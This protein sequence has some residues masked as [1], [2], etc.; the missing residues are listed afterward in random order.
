MI[1]TVTLNPC[2]DHVLFLDGLKVNDTNRVQRT[3]VDAGG[4]GVNVSRVAVELGAESLACGFLGGDPGTF[5]QS[6]L[7]I[8][9]VHHR[10]TKVGGTTRINFSVEDG[11]GKPPTTLNER[12]PKV[13]E[14]EWQQL[15][16]T[17]AEEAPKASWMSIG[18]SMPPGCPDDAFAQI[19]SLGKRSGCLV[20]LD[21]D[22]EPMRIGLQAKPHCIKPNEKEASRLLG[23]SLNS[24]QQVCE[25]AEEL[26]TLL[27]PGDQS[28]VVVS[29]GAAGAIYAD[30]KQVL[31]GES[32]KIDPVSTIGSGDSFIG[33]MLAATEKGLPREEAFGWGLAAGAATAT[34]D[35]SEIARRP[36]FERLLPNAV[37]RPAF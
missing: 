12:G 35:G 14:H 15:L 9:G 36:V 5:I 19:V 37:I 30:R 11:S 17:L 18:G 13:T 34:T 8:Q 3:E 20:M 21:A 33:G 24:D 31:I 7:E 1:L 32:P 29:R 23:R 26:L 16:A 4:K 27:D 6:I 22:H 10:F 28:W 25:A 2:I